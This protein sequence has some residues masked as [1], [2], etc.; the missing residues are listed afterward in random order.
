M[1]SIEA[2]AAMAASSSAVATTQ[3]Y[4]EF[5]SSKLGQLLGYKG[6]T[7]EKVKEKSGVSRLH[8]P[9]HEKERAKLQH[10]VP[11]EVQG[12]LEQIEH[13]RILLEGVASG[14][15]SELGHT[16]ALVAVEQSVIG[17]LMGYKGKTI[18]EM[19]SLTGAYIQIQQDRA[20]GVEDSPQLFIAGPPESVE[21]ATQ[22][23]LRFIASPGA[24]LHA[25]LYEDPGAASGAVMGSAMGTWADGSGGLV[26]H[27]Q[28]QQQLMM[29]PVDVTMPETQGALTGVAP[30]V[31]LTAFDP[32]GPKEERIIEIPAR[33][34]GHLLG[35]RGQTIDLVRKTSGVI[36]CHI[37]ADRDRG[38][39]SRQGTISVQVFGAADKVAACISLI[40]AIVAGDHTGIGH[41][42]DY[43][44][45][46][47]SKVDRIKADK[48][49]MVNSVKDLTNTYMDIMQGVEEGVPL[50]E[51]HL[52]MVGPPE[53]VE[54]A[55]TIVAAMLAIMDQTPAFSDSALTSPDII[56]HLINKVTPNTQRPMQ[57]QASV[58][59]LSVTL[60][61]HPRATSL[62][63]HV[64]ESQPPSA[65]NDIF[66]NLNA[67]ARSQS[68]A[69]SS[70][71][72][73]TSL[74][75]AMSGG[76]G[77]M[78]FAL[79]QAI[80]QLAS[81]SQHVAVQPHHQQHYQ[82]QHFGSRGAAIYPV[83]RSRSPRRFE[84]GFAGGDS[85]Y[86]G[87]VGMQVMEFPSCKLG[88]LLGF[89][90]LTIQ[91]LK[92]RCGL[93]RLHIPVHEK[94]RAKS[95]IVIPIE[96][97]GSPEQIEHCKALLEAVCNG[98]QSELGH[99]TSYVSVEPSVIGKLM[100]FKGRTVK[101][102]TE[103][104][105]AYIEIQQDRTKGMEDT[106]QLFVAGPSESVDRATDLIRRFIA[107]PG[108]DLRAV[109][110]EASAPADP[111]T[112]APIGTSLSPAGGFHVYDPEGPK[113][114]RI[115]DV[116]AKQ[117]H[118]L[119]GLHGQTIELIRHTSGVIKCH[120]QVERDRG[121]VEKVGCIPV[122]VFGAPDKV[123]ACVNLID[124]VL[125][126][127]HSGIGH[128]TEWW[129]IEASKV[130][131]LKGERWQVINAL[132]DLTNCFMDIM[133]ESADAMLGTEPQTHLF[134]AGP[135]E[136]VARAKSIVSALLSLMDQMPAN[137][138]A[139][140][141]IMAS[142]IGNL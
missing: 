42:S 39:A 134:V 137:G 132:K 80:S 97:H 122:Q 56:G 65:V 36:K 40:E 44:V 86:G 139:N 11:I 105:G 60:P 136:N 77:D 68:M 130:E 32:E 121:F 87:S 104:T 20:K 123:A 55:R 5:P 13:C 127:D 117:K 34:K 46:D 17:K 41:L 112:L 48:W 7:I 45:I 64:P 2:V 16:T 63:T 131:R 100:G 3:H 81:G 96:A 67:A 115:I 111:H 9:P 113:E 106:P 83:A 72:L 91:K 99:V 22:L 50:G 128:V 98:D 129:A 27:S 23:V 102:M 108:A 61:G 124:Q 107:S 52:F 126:G 84:S 142:L 119:L 92:E 73:A 125:R 79:N 4:V 109:L 74:Q 1:H 29:P 116:P 58:H 31:A 54:H 138:E 26:G 14:N 43:V 10:T 118:H 110:A 35:L 133:T 18:K 59:P 120:I 37:Q 57:K 33:R 12:T 6:L 62:Q 103:A 30:A 19:A 114:E 85:G 135:H 78:T 88:Q 71:D 47:P 53:N 28:F 95:Q 51:T 25:V 141:E 15:Q 90:G 21:Q 89:K 69:T 101:D 8:I 66:A 70:G 94:E 75:N 93:T 38:H 76:A 140:P 49:K 82:Q 24:N